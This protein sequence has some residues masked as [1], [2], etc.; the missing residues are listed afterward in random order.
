MDLVCGGRRAACRVC[1]PGDSDCRIPRHR[2]GLAKP[3]E[4]AI[5]ITLPGRTD[6]VTE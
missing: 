5:P 1:Q 3:L 2:F 6:E 4:F